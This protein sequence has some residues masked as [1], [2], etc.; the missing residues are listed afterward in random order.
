MVNPSRPW[1]IDSSVIVKWVSDEPDSGTAL[2]IRAMAADGNVIISEF[3]L[4]EVANALRFKASFNEQQT[5]R[6]IGTLVG[7]QITILPFDIGVL[8]DA[9]ESAY[10]YDLTV[11]DSYFVG[12]ADLEGLRLITADEKMAVKVRGHSDVMTLREFEESR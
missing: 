11:Y 5:R 10:R 1:L 6:A 3:S 9:I 2:A 7:S 4:F 8:A 12:L